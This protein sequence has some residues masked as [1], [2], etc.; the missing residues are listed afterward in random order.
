MLVELDLAS[1]SGGRDIVSCF[2]T[3]NP[4][5]KVYSGE[6]QCAALGMDVDIF[7]EEGNSIKQKK[8]ELVC[9]TPFPSSLF[10]FGMMIKISNI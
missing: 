9:K 5:M 3:G 4:N 8:G 2:V 7:D 10:I 1:I 6:I